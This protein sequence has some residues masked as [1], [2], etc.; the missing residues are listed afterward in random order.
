MFPVNKFWQSHGHGMQLRY[1]RLLVDSKLSWENFERFLTD[2]IVFPSSFW[3]K[4]GDDCN[5]TTV[6]CCL[7]P[8]DLF[9]CYKTKSIDKLYGRGHRDEHGCRSQCNI[10]PYYERGGKRWDNKS[11]E[12]VRRSLCDNWDVFNYISV[13]NQSLSSDTLFPN[14][15]SGFDPHDQILTQ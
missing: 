6:L 13:V 10:L 2:T 4:H 8:Y 14:S 1:Q 7:L 11:T 3:G 12:E 9:L 15:V 5:G